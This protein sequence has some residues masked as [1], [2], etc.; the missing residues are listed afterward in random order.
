MFGYVIPAHRRLSQ[1]GQK[2]YK[3]A[4]CGLCCCLKERYGFRSRFLVNYDMTFLYCLLSKER[5]CAFVPG[6]CPLHPFCKRECMPADP[7]MAYAADMTVLLS[8]WKLKDALEDGRW[9]KKIGSGLALLVY[10]KPYKRAAALHPREN[11]LF[12]EQL[13][14]LGDLEKQECGSLD[15]VADTFATLLHGCVGEP[16]TPEERRILETLLYH[17]GR[18][19]Y[20][21]DALEDL[22]EDQKHGR[23]N[24]L[25]H[26]YKVEDGKLSEADQKELV[27]TVE[28]SISIAASALELM[29]PNGNR[30]ILENIIYEGLPA[31]LKSICNGSFRKRRTGNEGSL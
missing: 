28:A 12:R 23:Y 17:V 31:V 25:A 1:E 11:D 14:H 29:P 2:R 4:Y 3:A 8:W 7:V 15:R 24:P 16:A 6:A 9:L 20:L 27:D 21:A 18:Y 26:R 10:R 13:Q 19:L 30:D 5:E 22:P